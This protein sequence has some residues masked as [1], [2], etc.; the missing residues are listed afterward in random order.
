RVAGELRIEI[1]GAEVLAGANPE[2]AWLS[3][4]PMKLT[5]GFHDLRIFY[6][7]TSATA[8]V[9]LYWSSESFP[10]EPVSTFLL[11]PS[12]ED[13]EQVAGARDLERGRQLYDAHRCNQCHIAP[14]EEPGMPAPALWG[15]TEGLNPQWLAAK[16]QGTHREASSSLMPQ[17]GLSAQEAGD[18][19]VFL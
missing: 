2:P 16:L 4:E 9:N 15:V 8:R 13:E 10:L 17:F 7:K 3:A 11:A 12:D 5:P 6:R 18:I 1:D 14:G 19:A